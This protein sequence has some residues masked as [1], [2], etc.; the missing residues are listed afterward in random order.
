MRPPVCSESSFH[1]QNLTGSLHIWHLFGAYG[2]SISSPAGTDAG[3]QT[4]L[5]CRVLT[6]QAIST[7]R[8]VVKQPWIK[9]LTTIT[10]RE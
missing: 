10:R 8:V 9:G 4:T 6:T 1:P 2:I 5:Y 7:Q 3:V